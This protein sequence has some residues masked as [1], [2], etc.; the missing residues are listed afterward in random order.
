MIGAPLV[1]PLSKLA[2][3]KMDSQTKISEFSKALASG[4]FKESKNALQQIQKEIQE[5]A[6]GE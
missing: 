3:A 4:D 1:M 6:I 5:A 2:L